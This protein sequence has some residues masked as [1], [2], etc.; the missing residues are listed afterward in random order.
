MRLPL[1]GPTTLTLLL[2]TALNTPPTK[3]CTPPPDPT[4]E[5]LL[6][7]APCTTDATCQT[8]TTTTT[9][10]P[11]GNEFCFHPAHR[12][13]PR[14]SAGT[15]CT[16]D[17]ECISNYCQA[18][19]CALS[20]TGKPC[21]TVADCNTDNTAPQQRWVCAPQT[22]TCLLGVLGLGAPCLGDEQCGFG[23]CAAGICARPAG[24][25]GAVCRQ[26]PECVAGLVCTY[27][28]FSEDRATKMCQAAPGPGAYGAPCAGDGDCVSGNCG[29]NGELVCGE[30]RVCKEEGEGCWRDADCC[31]GGCRFG[32]LWV[33]RT[34]EV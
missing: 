28:L 3:A 31:R 4:P 12:C 33:W 21:G 32:R 19:S 2:L 17:P 27:S 29:V 30:P 8:T 14:L 26:T 11:P 25:Y 15:C 9:A 20:Q 13:L 5:Y 16:T 6:T 22:N 10:T 23:R 34:C 1:P 7:R 24:E 18:G